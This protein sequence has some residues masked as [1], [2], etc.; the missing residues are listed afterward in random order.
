MHIFICAESNP[1]RI[2]WGVKRVQRPLQFGPRTEGS[3]SAS[4]TDISGSKTR[5]SSGFI[6]KLKKLLGFRVHDK[7]ESG[8]HSSIIQVS[9]TDR[10]SC[11]ILLC[12][13]GLSM[14][15]SINLSPT[16][17]ASTLVLSSTQK[18][19]L[20]STSTVIDSQLNNDLRVNTTDH[21]GNDIIHGKFNT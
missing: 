4:A 19:I 9:F 6:G 3:T 20:D 11:I 15:S 8:I 12:N 14:S 7:P 13:L 2:E 5:K 1:V 10:T 17:S 18:D 21:E 16:K